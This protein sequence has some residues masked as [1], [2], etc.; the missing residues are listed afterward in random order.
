MQA[1][2][3]ENMLPI[4]LQLGS[5]LECKLDTKKKENITSK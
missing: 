3:Q 2:F 1:E 4:H 5:I